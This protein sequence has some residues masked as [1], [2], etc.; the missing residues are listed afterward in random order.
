M[1]VSSFD[2]LISESSGVKF[3]V[4]YSSMAEFQLREHKKCKA[5]AALGTEKRLYSFGAGWLFGRRVPEDL[6]R[7]IDKKILDLRVTDKMRELVE[8]FLKPGSEKECAVD[9]GVIE[10]PIVLLPLTV[11]VGPCL[12]ILAVVLVIS[13]RHP[14][15]SECEEQHIVAGSSYDL[16]DLSVEAHNQRAAANAER[17]TDLRRRH[18]A[19]R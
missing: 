5:F 13:W 11:L 17:A 14:I 15:N 10:A 1:T 6:R 3:A 7:L 2:L 16:T 9:R 12:A 18:S 19:A 4:M 8:E